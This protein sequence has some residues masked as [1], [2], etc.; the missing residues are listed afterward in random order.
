M[1]VIMDLVHLPSYNF[2]SV[3]FAPGEFSDSMSGML[4]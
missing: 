3:A 2:F 4:F 1:S